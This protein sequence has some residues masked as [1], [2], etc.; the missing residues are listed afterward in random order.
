M[1]DSIISTK[2]HIPLPRPTIVERPRLIDQL[3]QGCQAKL[4]LISA[5]AGYGKSSLVSNWAHENSIPVTWLTLDKLD[6]DVARFVN[7]FVAALKKFKSNFGDMIL[8][9]LESPQIPSHQNLLSRLINELS[10]LDGPHILVLDDYHVITNR[11]IRELI[12]FL[13]E[14]LPSQIHLMILTRSD[15]QFS[16][17]R[18]R[19]RGQLLEIRA[20]HLKF[21]G[22]ETEAFFNDRMKM[23]L[24]KEEVSAFEERTEGWITG[25]QL[26]SLALQGLNTKDIK[27]FADAF[28]GS[29]F[30]IVDYLVE[31]VLNRQPEAIREFLLRT[32]IL[33]QMTGVLCNQITGRDDSQSMLEKLEQENL[34][35]I[36][37]DD[38]R[39]WYRYHHLFADVLQSHLRA[40]APELF[41]KL[42]QRAAVWFE[43]QGFFE[44]AIRHAAA[45]N[46]LETAAEL[47]E[48]NAVY[49]LG[50]GELF[51]LLSLIE[52][53]EAL[54]NERPWLCIYKSW[55]LALLGQLDQAD[56]WCQKAKAIIDANESKPNRRML[57]HIAA[58][59][60]YCTTYQGKTDAA[61]AQKALECLPENE[62]VIRSIVISTIGS[63]LRFVGEYAQ[64]EEALESTRQTAREAGNNYLELYAL[65]TLS[66][67][68]YYQ[69]QLHKSYKF[70]QD[71]LQMSTLPNG[72]MDPSASWALK[73]LGYINY[74]WNDLVAAEKYTQMALDLGPKWGEPIELAH[75]FLLLSQINIAKRDLSSAQ[76]AFEKGEEVIHTNAV[77]SGLVN[78]I[79]AQKAH[80]WIKLGDLK[81]ADQWAQKSG[82]SA[83]DEISL[84]RT[85]QYR[86][87]VRVALAI[88][89]YNAALELL[90]R[91]QERVEAAGRTRSL[92]QTLVL[93]AL[94]HQVA[95]DIPQALS[96]LER[97]ITL[98]R[99]GGYIR[100]FVDEGEPMEKLLRLAQAREISKDYIS[101]ILAAFQETDIVSSPS[102]QLVEPLSDRELEVLCLIADGLSNQEIADRLII[103]VGT[104]KAHT[105]NIYRKLNVN[106]RMQ[107][108]ARARDLRLL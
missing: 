108:V 3:N 52:L 92:I 15:P 41:E 106:S 67:V 50:H 23:T 100:I 43:K 74:E 31:E 85:N 83:K 70:A 73:G 24:S 51:T 77:S 105:V 84:F 81:A 72:Q 103:A 2:I 95:N 49:M 88:E 14:N 66:A 11:T 64:A 5:P 16:L 22:A 34:F 42:H 37:L 45:G 28:S 97:I 7:Y 90:I 86:T 91:L 1:E 36:P 89:N 69:G 93:R 58:V 96:V 55:A 19:A 82:I 18:L 57:G 79:E 54:L 25:L 61:Y 35:L 39:Q 17:S 62:Q 40:S 30:Y 26:V 32:S 56:R 38:K 6:N 27:K 12:T 21:T 20:D 80:Y 33:E 94:A 44:H 13:I 104:V 10:S 98:T 8:P 75:M 29:H 4:T 68:T 71:A 60:F 47:V 63:S 53:L 76:Q 102:L 78:W 101:K 48:T 46:L 65:T 107:A 9:L 99:P 87:W 59:Q